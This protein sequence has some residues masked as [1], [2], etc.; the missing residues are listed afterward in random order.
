MDITVLPTLHRRIS[1]ATLRLVLAFGLA[2]GLLCTGFFFAGR[3]PDSLVSRNYDSVALARQMSTALAGWRFPE[4]YVGKDRVA[5]QTEFELA[6][7][8]ARANVTETG[9][10]AAVDA[11]ARS[12]SELLLAG[13]EDADMS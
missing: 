1:Q 5:W 13:P 4:L 9:E 8:G 6:L 10:Q 2:G 7:A 3:A 12:W 11:V